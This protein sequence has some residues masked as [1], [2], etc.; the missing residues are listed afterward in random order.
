MFVF[1][2]L[3][4]VMVLIETKI[5]FISYQ[6]NSKQNFKILFTIN[7]THTFEQCII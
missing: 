2:G 3:D 7:R 5:C 6:T 1:G 4:T